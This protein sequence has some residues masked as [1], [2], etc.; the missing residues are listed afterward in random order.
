MVYKLYEL[1]YEEVKVVDPDFSLTVEEYN[2]I[3][4]EQGSEN[5]MK[6]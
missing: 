3:R 1:T 5:E 6:N 4:I 2:Q